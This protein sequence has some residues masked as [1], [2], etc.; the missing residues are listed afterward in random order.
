MCHVAYPFV[1]GTTLEDVIEA[2]MGGTMRLLK[3]ATESPSVK[4]F[5]YCSS[6]AAVGFAPTYPDDVIIDDDFYTPEDSPVLD[7]YMKSKILVEKAM[8]EYIRS[9]ENKTSKYPITMTSLCPYGISGPLP[10]GFTKF[11]GFSQLVG[12]AFQGQLDQIPNMYFKV[13][14]VRDLADAFVVAT[15]DTQ[16]YNERFLIQRENEDTMTEALELYKK[17]FPESLTSKFPTE[18]GPVWL[19]SRKS[20]VQ[21]ARKLLK[22]NPYSSEETLLETAKAVLRNS[23]IDY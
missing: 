7:G 11:V 2:A 21:K 16:T 19:G 3:M 9:D 22:Y 5:V 4:H 23:N 14:D 15:T 18:L 20:T 8:W 12:A 13:T 1:N 17:T 10:V 6:F